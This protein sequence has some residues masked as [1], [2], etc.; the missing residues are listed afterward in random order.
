MAKDAS[1]KHEDYKLTPFNIGGLDIETHGF[2]GGFILGGVRHWDGRY[3]TFE[4]PEDMLDF[5]M[6]TPKDSN[7]RRT[8][9]WM[10][11]H[12]GAGF[13]FAYLVEAIMNLQDCEIS[14]INQG[15]KFIGAVITKA[16]GKRRYSVTL[17]DSVA[18]C[19]ASLEKMTKA[20]APH[21]PKS[22]HCP[23]HDF[24][25]GGPDFSPECDFCMKYL[26]IDVDSMIEAV[27]GIEST[28]HRE[29]GV[30][31]SI[32][33]GSIA[34]KAAKH[35]LKETD[36][37]F[38]MHSEKE[39]F[40]RNA[41][42]GGFVWAGHERGNHGPARTYDM[43][44]AYAARL[45][46]GLPYG[47]P[48]W[49]TKYN[50]DEPGIWD[51][52]VSVPD[53]IEIPLIAALDGGYPTGTFR[54]T[55]TSIEIEEAKLSG[56]RF[57]YHTGIVFAEIVYPFN[58]FIQTCQSLEYPADGSSPDPAVKN[59][60][61]LLRNALPGKF[62]A[63]GI[64]NKYYVSDDGNEGSI[65]VVDS[66]GIET[67]V[68][69]DE[70]ELEGAGYIHPEWNAW[71]TANQR[72]LIRRALLAGGV[73]SYYSDTDSIT[74]DPKMADKLEADG[75]L[76]TGVGYGLY[77]DEGNW[78]EFV[79]A[80]PKLKMGLTED[81][82][83]TTSKGVPTKLASQ[84]P[85]L[86][87]LASQGIAKPEDSLTWESP[88]SFRYRLTHPGSPYGTTR[89]RRFSLIENSSNWTVKN[90]IIRPRKAVPC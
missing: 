60:V 82:W 87:A 1:F 75:L 7:R 14:T 68:W 89:K 12:N 4:T 59:I 77:H 23:D 44:G 35:S 78:L 45:R 10:M 49:A 72:I 74:L 57:K 70:V 20:F 84:H 81:G 63:Q 26:Q 22:E 3:E 67:G 71:I 11:A 48:A 73:F 54:T 40:C 88:L 8:S 90:N 76:P 80:A 29:F 30:P 47:H 38:R 83:K 85:D 50:A 69:Y 24:T 17:I 62:A 64:A 46:D 27:R 2:S 9:G 58:D 41:V 32:T 28:L 86:I 6:D 53:D 34:I 13:D 18:I 15:Q 19:P 16:N 79:V 37:F 39:D 65:P 52:T 55:T 33:A 61:K 56:C 66:Q 36:C 25:K 5:V 42:H 31:L 43:S 51:V 21:M